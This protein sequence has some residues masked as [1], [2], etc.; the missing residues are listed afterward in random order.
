MR[1]S[2]E[3]PTSHNSAQARSGNDGEVTNE[4]PHHAEILELMKAMAIDEGIWITEHEELAREL[5]DTSTQE[6]EINEQTRG[7]D[8]KSNE[9]DVEED[10]QEAIKLCDFCSPRKKPH[11]MR[12]LMGNGS[13]MIIRIEG[14]VHGFAP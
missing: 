14:N 13:R 6:G 4:V 5:F 12:C 10:D 9:G 11:C 2:N 1:P 7:E 8:S 3:V